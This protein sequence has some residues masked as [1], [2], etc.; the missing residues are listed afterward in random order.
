VRGAIRNDRPYR[1]TYLIFADDLR[2]AGAHAL[3]YR[4]RFCSVWALAIVSSNEETMRCSISFGWRRLMACPFLP[5][6][7]WP[8]PTLFPKIECLLWL[9]PFPHCCSPVPALSCRRRWRA[10]RSRSP[11]SN[12]RGFLQEFAW[13]EYRT[14]PV[15]GLT[16]P[17]LSVKVSWRQPQRAYFAPSLR[18]KLSTCASGMDSPINKGSPLNASYHCISP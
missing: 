8:S 16:T 11:Y 6:P 2:P 9:F 7:S 18:Q 14:P 5:M 15:D 13:G 1:V 17:V 10:A 4:F 3:P 12:L